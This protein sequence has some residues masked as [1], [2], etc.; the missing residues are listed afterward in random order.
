M[1]IL[2]RK[3]METIRINDDITMCVVAIRGDKVRIGFDAPKSV[4][5]HRGEIYDAIQQ[6]T[7]AEN[8]PSCMPNLEVA[9]KMR[10]YADAIEG[11]GF[12]VNCHLETFYLKPIQVEQLKEAFAE[13]GFESNS[14]KG[15]SWLKAMPI[16]RRVSIT[17]Y[18]PRP[19]AVEVPA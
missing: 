2:S 14:Y 11:L 8:V 13:A 19:N 5:I 16:D 9:Q 6:T 18:S 7:Q 10:E 3:T 4:V 12:P 15:E 1:L 17:A